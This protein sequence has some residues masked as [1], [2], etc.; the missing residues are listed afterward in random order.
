MITLSQAIEQ[1]L[2]T[3]SD[4][5]ADINATLTNITTFAS[6]S[7]ESLWEGIWG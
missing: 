1:V 2:S 3:Q 5:G 7:L 6:T 4:Q